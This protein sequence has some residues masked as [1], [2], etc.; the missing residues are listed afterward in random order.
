MIWESIYLV[1]T[2]VKD[3]EAI[4]QVLIGNRKNSE[5]RKWTILGQSYGGFCAIHYLSYY[6]DSLKEVFLTGGLA[7]LVDRPDS[8]YEAL[9]SEFL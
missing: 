1:L 9:I 3:C 5:D 2:T 6:G 4:R 8:V 7:P